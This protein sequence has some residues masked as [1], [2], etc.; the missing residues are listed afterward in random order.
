[1][2]FPKPF[3]RSLRTGSSPF[4]R[5]L[6]HKFCW[7]STDITRGFVELQ[8]SATQAASNLTKFVTVSGNLQTLA[9]YQHE[10]L[11]PDVREFIDFW[12]T[13]DPVTPFVAG[14]LV[15]STYHQH[16]LLRSNPLLSALRFIPIQNL[17]TPSAG[18]N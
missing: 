2:R 5:Y 1:M 8:A 3:V 18:G 7:T 14:K 10:Q 9:P 16:S 13:N 12:I 4:R 11:V 15:H 6:A 17:P